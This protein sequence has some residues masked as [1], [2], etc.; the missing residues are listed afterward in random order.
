MVAR[1]VNVHC[2]TP[3]L[4]NLLLFAVSATPN[5]YQGRGDGS[6]VD[7]GNYRQ[8]ATRRCVPGDQDA[9]VNHPGEQAVSTR[10][11]SAP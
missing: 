8:Y 3:D 2:V 5:V 10:N 4:L 11:G 9:A 6:P 1:Y 7:G